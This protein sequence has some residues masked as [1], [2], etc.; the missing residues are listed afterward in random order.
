MI[1]TLFKLVEVLINVFQSTIVMY[2]AYKYLGDK[3]DRNFWENGGVLFSIALTIFLSAVNYVTAFEDIVMIFYIIFVLVYA[4]MKLKGKVLAK[5]FASAYQVM[6]NCI[7]G[8]LTANFY[9]VLFNKTLE[10]LLSV[11]G[12]ARF[13]S[14]ISTQL[15]IIYVYLISIR[16]LKRD[17]DNLL[18]KQEWMIII[19]VFIMSIIESGILNIISLQDVNET[20]RL[21]ITVTVVCIIFINIVTISLVTSLSKKNKL[22]QENKELKLEK[23]YQQQLVNKSKEEYEN[24]RKIRHDYKNTYNLIY[25][26]IKE[27][28]LDEA[29]EYIEKN[30]EAVESI[31]KIVNTG[32]EI[33][34]AIVSNKI[35]VA[36]NKGIETSVVSVSD[37]NGLDNLDISAILGNLYDNAIEA[38]KKCDLGNKRIE[39]KIAKKNATYI[40]SMKNTIKGS[41]LKNNPKLETTKKE[42][43]AHGL[44]TKI[45]KDHVKKYNGTVDYYEEYGYFCCMIMLHI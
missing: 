14:L 6:C 9:S 17:K 16:M 30:L 26:L 28:R 27:N 3:K 43:E 34:N 36:N 15:I 31:G 19:I 42:K 20:A 12:M 24:I 21:M 25:A 32:N 2:F 23:A 44:G 33:I 5:L 38:C 45:I 40:I 29:K 41:V 18:Q 7:I 13:I 39:L 22:S 37:F 4:V 10:E 35:T 1:E 8:V 11:Y